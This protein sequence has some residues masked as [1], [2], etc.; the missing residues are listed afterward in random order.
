MQYLTLDDIVGLHLLSDKNL[1]IDEQDSLQLLSSIEN[2][3]N[4][5][6]YNR[7]KE[8]NIDKRSGKA[9]ISA[10]LSVDFNYCKEDVIIVKGV[11]ISGRLNKYNTQDL[12]V[13][14]DK[15]RNLLLCKNNI[16]SKFLEILYTQNK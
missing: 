2:N 12:F 15:F 14:C 10:M 16:I 1:I 11:L 7:L 6:L 13:G 5:K 9:I 3:N 8:Y 4:E